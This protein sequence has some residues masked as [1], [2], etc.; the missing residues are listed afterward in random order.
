MRSPR[1]SVS[2]L[3][4][5]SCLVGCG[6]DETAGTTGSPTDPGISAA[7]CPAAPV[8]ADTEAVAPYWLGGLVALQIAE[9]TGHATGFEV[10]VF[11]PAYQG[12]RASYASTEIEPASGS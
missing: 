11:D 1:L 5:G 3:V 10:Q 6:D 8:V 9:P 12:W 7:D 4:V 2:V